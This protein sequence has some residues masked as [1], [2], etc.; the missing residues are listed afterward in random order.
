[1]SCCVD[2][3]YWFYLLFNNIAVKSKSRG[4]TFLTTVTLQTIGVICTAANN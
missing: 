1:M 2:S 4:V 3:F